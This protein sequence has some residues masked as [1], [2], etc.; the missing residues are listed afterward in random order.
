MTLE[1]SWRTLCE[2]ALTIIRLNLKDFSLERDV[3]RAK[4]LALQAC[5]IILPNIRDILLLKELLEYVTK[6]FEMNSK[7]VSMDE[8]SLLTELRC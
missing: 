3:L 7:S 1:W 6:L 4:V 2:T 5:E 8:L